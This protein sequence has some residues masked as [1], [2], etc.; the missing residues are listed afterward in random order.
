M[1]NFFILVLSIGER[2]WPTGE[3]SYLVT[4]IK[5]VL[6]LWQIR[7]VSQNLHCQRT[8]LLLFSPEIYMP[9]STLKGNIAD[10]TEKN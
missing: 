8:F 3:H 6:I 10:H 9:C 5:N 4:M 1:G 2:I 7:M